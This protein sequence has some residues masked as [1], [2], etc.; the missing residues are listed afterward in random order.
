MTVRFGT[1]GWRGIIG[2]DFT[3]DNLARIAAS[4][5]LFFD[6]KQWDKKLIIGYDSR[7]QSELFAGFLALQ[8]SENGFFVHLFEE[9]CPT[10]VLSFYTKEFKCNLGIMITASHNPFYYNGVKF[11]LHY[12]GPPLDDFTSEFQSML[13][14]EVPDY[15][16]IVP[17]M[18]DRIEA[19]ENIA[20]IRNSDCYILE[21]RKH[22][23]QNKIASVKGT[24][25]YNAMFGAGQKMIPEL[26]NSYNLSYEEMATEPNP[27]FQNQQPEPIP[28]YLEDFCKTLSKGDYCCGLA[29]DGDADR[30]AVFDE[31]GRFVQMFELIAL[32]YQYLIEVKNMRGGVVYSASL[33]DMPG[34]IADH[35]D[36]LNTEAP[37]GFK[38]IASELYRGDYLIGAEESGGIGFKFLIPERDGVF[39]SQLLLEIM[40]HYQKPLSEI[41]VDLRK[42]WGQ[43][44]YKR[45]DAYCPHERLKKNFAFLKENTPKKI[46]DSPVT[47][48]KFI[49]GLKFF[50][51]GGW[52]LM[53]M[54]QTEPLGRIYVAG[55]ND[56]HVEH[57]LEMGSKLL[58]NE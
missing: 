39:C 1:D 30:I 45:I 58:F 14:D 19:D 26:L 55:K 29:T 5:A 36:F 21:T 4:L 20:V 27:G 16:L 53:R 18:K 51:D 40:G 15:E 50:V 52:V 31:N 32:F 22:L 47:G 46:G 37:V 49:D 9:L 33:V 38:H 44:S 12:G 24:V 41:L 7:F 57:L 35:Y 13:I 54:S 56:D 42:R 28:E 3:Y 25:L 2:K 8:L 48:F 6:K 11:K 17:E 43:N 23:D 34:R 10:P